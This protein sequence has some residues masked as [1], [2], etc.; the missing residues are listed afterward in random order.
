MIAGISLTACRTARTVDTGPVIVTQERNSDSAAVKHITDSVVI[1]DSVYIVEAARN[2]T[3]YITR[4]RQ[5]VIT[6]KSNRVDTLT[7]IKT[8]KVPQV[9]KVTKSRY[10][11]PLKVYAAISLFGILAGLCV[12][13]WIWK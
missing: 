13:R 12:G 11:H 3:V 10:K 7:V 5:R 4:Y 2:D 1:H 6:K 9:V 8:V